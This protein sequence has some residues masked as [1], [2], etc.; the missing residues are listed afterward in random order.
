MRVSFPGSLLVDSNFIPACCRAC[1]AASSRAG[2][3]VVLA[4]AA[5]SVEKEGDNE[6]VTPNVGCA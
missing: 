5:G 6:E 3:S 1:A 4:A 2:C